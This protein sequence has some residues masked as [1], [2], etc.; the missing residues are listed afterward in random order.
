MRE[1]SLHSWVLLG[2]LLFPLVI[3]AQKEEKFIG[4]V[5]VMNVVEAECTLKDGM[6]E[7]RFRD[8]KKRRF[9]K[10]KSFHFPDEDKNYFHLKTWVTQGFESVPDEPRLLGFSEETVEIQFRKSAGLVS[11]RFAMQPM[12]K[13]KKIYSSWLVKGK[14]EK[15]FGI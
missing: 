2:I 12:G 9:P 14:A 7:I 15:L 4:E 8:A 13:N 5:R 11:F 6:Y 10:Y 1:N 3:Q